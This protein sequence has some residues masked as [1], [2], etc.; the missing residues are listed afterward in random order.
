MST[1]LTKTRASSSFPV[2]RMD[3]KFENI[4]KYW[5]DNDPALTHFFTGMSTLLPEG[6]DYFLRIV[7]SLRTKIKD[8]NKLNTDVGAFIGQEAMHSKEHHT[9]HISAQ[10]HDLDPESLEK[11]TGYVLKRI[12]KVFPEKW[13]LSLVAGLEHYTATLAVEMM[14]NVQNR[15]TDS[16]IRHLWLWHSIEETEHKAV[17]YDFYEYLYGK[18]LKAYIPRVSIY[19]FGLFLILSLSILFQLV[20]M[21]RDKQLLNIKS[22]ATYL[23]FMAETGLRITPS[24]LSYYNFNF[25]PNKTNEF[26]LLQSMK[27][28]I[29]L[30]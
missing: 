13:N 18:N 16:T 2:R 28:Q 7:R 14:A 1:K 23:K 5:C 21:K 10:Q 22:W 25:H 20:L 4:K 27:R 15:I 29:G 8:N 9:F 19:T 26:E 24:F 17:V 11:M 6:E 12:E 3:Y 30:Q